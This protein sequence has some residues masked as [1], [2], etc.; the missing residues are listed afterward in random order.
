MSKEKLQVHLNLDSSKDKYIYNMIFNSEDRT[1]LIKNALFYY[2]HE[3]KIGRVRDRYYPYDEEGGV[4]ILPPS[5][6]INNNVNE[7]QYNQQSNYVEQEQ[8]QEEIEYEDEY[9]EDE[10]IE[11]EYVEDEDEDDNMDDIDI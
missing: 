11:D 6:E 1:N 3:I 8:E 7:T 5:N 2:M 9:I 10:Y 4:N